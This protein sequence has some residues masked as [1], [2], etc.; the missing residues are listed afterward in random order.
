MKKISTV[1][2]PQNP[3]EGSVYRLVPHETTTPIYAERTDRNIGWITQNEQE[4]LRTKVVGIAGCGGMGGLVAS[5][6]LRLGVGEIRIADMETFDVSNINRQFAANRHTIGKSKAFETAKMLREIANDTVIEVYPMGINE[7][8][9]EDFTQGCDIIC[10]EI[11]FWAIGSRILLH[12]FCRKNNVQIFNSPTVG[13]RAYIFKF[14]PDSMRIE[15]VLGMEYEEAIVLQLGL[16]GDIRLGDDTIQKIMNAMIRFAAPEI[17][18]Y[19]ADT[20]IYSTVHAIKK[21]L[22][23]KVQ[24]SIIA[25]N[26]PMA[27]GF[28]SNHVLFDLLQS[29]SIE[30]NF[31]HAPPMPGYVFFDAGLLTCGKVETRWW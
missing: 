1:I 17:P 8:C 22:K 12:K 5:I 31:V 20:N 18:E 2:L 13:H 15:E 6:L 28:L 21:R 16:Q 3:H 24:A 19:M 11:E 30:R 9:V 10:D 26:P 29:S 27:A 25:S 14:T 7:D 23:E 4:L